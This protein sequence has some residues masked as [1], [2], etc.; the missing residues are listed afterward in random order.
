MICEGLS[1]C[2]N[3][4]SVWIIIFTSHA[5]RECVETHILKLGWS[6]REARSIFGCKKIKFEYL[7]EWIGSEIEENTR[8]IFYYTKYMCVRLSIIDMMT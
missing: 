7:F 2:S 1:K 8:K 3:V 4:L 5:Q 6:G